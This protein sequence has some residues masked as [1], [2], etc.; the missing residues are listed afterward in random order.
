MT[1][2]QTCAMRLTGALLAATA[3]TAATAATA[4]AFAD[5]V[6]TVYPALYGEPSSLDPLYDTNL[7]ALNVYYA[8]YNRLATIDET[9]AVQPDL[10][11]S[12]S[13]SDDL[14]EWT[15]EL[16]EGVSCHDGAPMDSSDVVFTYMTAKSDP[17]SRLGG[18]YGLV[19]SVEA[20]SPTTVVFKLS[21]P[22]APFDRQTTLA[23]I[24]CQEA[25]EAM[26]K[27][28][29]GRAPVGSG[30]YK[31]VEWAAGDAIKTTRF[32]GYFG[33]PG[34][35]PNVVFKPVPDETTRANSVQSGDLSVALLGPSQVPA[36]KGGGAVD[37]VDQPSN[38]VIYLGFN[39][40]FPFLGDEKVRKAIDLA[41]DRTLIGENL[42][43]GLVEPMAQLV[44][45]VTFGYN[46]SLTPTAQ[47]VEKAKALLAEAGYDG[48][49]I[50]L[51]YPT[52]GL[53]QIDQIAQAVAYFL[54]Q[55]G[56]KTELSPMEQTTFLNT[57]FTGK[58]QG[59]Y[60]FAFAP[61][62]MDASLPL[63]M[64]LKTGGQGYTFDERI[65]ALLLEQIG[66]ADPEKRAALLGEISS[67][68]YERTL[69]APLFNDT[70]TYGVTKGLAWQSRPDGMMVF[71]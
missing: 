44:A 45:P 14:K 7:P 11:K 43:N 59:I 37:V 39:S 48:T 22:F 40:S 10:A 58:L 2:R 24:V 56:V 18:Y 55:V 57:W 12:W 25:Y 42:L 38:R 47:D 53:P 70:Y 15:F 51:E 20:T 33:K 16:T 60:I 66:E 34:G 69:Y 3:L 32:E 1:K 28:A 21:A 35:Y 67:I 54:D 19:E 8:V 5:P 4:P 36:V 9:G 49:P 64:L 46:P 31:F 62:V 29:F 13:H 68:V 52:T 27:E 23:A 41:V 61:S 63:N 26:G 17:K 71:R 50:I 65:D 6:E 30:P